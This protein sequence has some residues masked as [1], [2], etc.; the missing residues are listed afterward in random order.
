MD[1]DLVLED[2]SILEDMR[3][4]GKLRRHQIVAWQK[5]WNTLIAAHGATNGMVSSYEEQV[6]KSGPGMTD[7]YMFESRAA[8]ERAIIKSHPYIYI[9]PAGQEFQAVWGFLRAEERGL[10]EQ[11][12]RDYHRA[13]GNH[14]IHAPTLAALGFIL[15]GYQDNRQQIAAGV[16]SVQRLLNSI[17][18]F[19]GLPTFTH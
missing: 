2:G 18:E 11:I 10:I 8:L 17:A 3:R 5:W 16:A 13:S 15:S 19:Y 14:E 4:R 6:D 12:T 7:A 9:T 1:E